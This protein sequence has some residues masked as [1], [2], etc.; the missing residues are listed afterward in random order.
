M[1][2]RTAEHFRLNNPAI[3]VI[4]AAVLSVDTT[5]KLVHLDDSST[6]SYDKLCVCS[7]ARPKLITSHPHVI[8]LRDLQ[9]VSYMADKL[10][11]AAARRVV[12]LGNGG[13]ALELVHSLSFCE[14]DWVIRDNY[15]GSAF[16]DASASAFIMPE[17][18]LR[19]K[20]TAGQ[21]S[22]VTMTNDEDVIN[23]NHNSSSNSSSSSS[24]S[25]ARN[26]DGTRTAGA[27]LG[28]EWLKKSDF[29]AQIPV[30]VKV[31]ARAHPPINTPHSPCY[32]APL[33]ILTLLSSPL[34]RV[35]RVT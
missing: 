29:L 27:A 32:H 12:V 9:S 8:G 24:S 15:I 31:R 3:Q 34:V 16:F 10:S 18:L 7:G 33:A 19:A 22:Y 20:T 13:I 2:E 28:P 25:N 5:A 30:D 14:I 6:I 17:L 23:N 4:Q 35:P 21:A 26:G 1:Y 11:S